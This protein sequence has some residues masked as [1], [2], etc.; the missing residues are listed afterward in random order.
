MIF[1][2]IFLGTRWVAFF[3]L[4][5]Y[6]L[7]FTHSTWYSAA[8]VQRQMGID[9]T[10]PLL[11]GV[12]FDAPITIGVIRVVLSAWVRDHH[13]VHP[14]SDSTSVQTSP[15]YRE[16][17]KKVVWPIERPKRIALLLQVEGWNKEEEVVKA[18]IPR[19]VKDK[20][21][22]AKGKVPKVVLGTDDEEETEQE[23]APRRRRAT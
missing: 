12:H 6:L 20:A 17:M 19:S 15:E 14:I 11:G 5:I 18:K 13:L 2:G 21:P 16:W 7:G 4:G 10:V 9:Q 1:Y 22:K 8:R 23:C 3:R